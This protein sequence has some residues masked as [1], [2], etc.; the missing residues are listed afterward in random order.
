MAES[1]ILELSNEPPKR[2][3]NMTGPAIVVGVDGSPGADHALRWALGLAE[4]AGGSVKAAMS[5]EYP[6]LAMLPAP[7]GMP[8][9][10]PEQMDAATAGALADALAPIRPESSVEIEEHVRRGGGAQVLLAAADGADLLV[11]GSRGRGRLAS[12]LLGSVSR[13]VAAEAACP[14]IVVPQAASLE[15]TGPVVV[16]VDGSAASVEALRWA[17]KM[18]H[19]PIHAIHV[20]EYPFGPEYA[21]DEFEWADPQDLGRKLLEGVVAEALGDR[22]D[23]TRTAA[24]GDAREVLVEAAADASLLVVGARG[25]GGVEGA[26]L[27]S[28]ATGVASSARVPVAVVPTG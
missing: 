24:Q 10:P 21:I 16:G 18:T 28:V 9:P 7:L 11:V 4:R 3:R 13:R 17:G 15:H 26:L 2:R 5:W 14:V 19:G 1:G 8:L 22:P 25:A 12:V 20:F 27:G 23:V 6:A